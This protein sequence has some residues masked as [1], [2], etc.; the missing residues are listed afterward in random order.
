VGAEAIAE[1][2]GVGALGKRENAHV[3]RVVAE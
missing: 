2:F 1:L 3:P